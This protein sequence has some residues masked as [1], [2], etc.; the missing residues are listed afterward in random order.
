MATLSPEAAQ[1]EPTELTMMA[2]MSATCIILR[3]FILPSL[4]ESENFSKALY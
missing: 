3:N 1:A 4:K 2:T